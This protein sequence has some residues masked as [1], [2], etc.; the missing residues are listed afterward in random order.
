MKKSDITVILSIL[1]LIAVSFLIKSSMNKG[2]AAYVVINLAGEEYGRYDLHKDATIELDKNTVVIENNKVYMKDSDCPDHLCESQGPISKSGESIVC[3]PNKV[4]VLIEG[5][6]D[7]ISKTDFKLGTIVSVKI[8]DSSDEKIL[9]GCME[10]CDKYEAVCSRTSQS[11]ELYK[12]N[13][14]LI[15]VNSDGSY[16]VSDELY[17]MIEEGLSYSEMS[18]G[19]FD[20]SIGSLTTL[21]NFT[22]SCDNTV[23]SSADIDKALAS[24]SY[25][26]IRLD[27]DNRVFIDNPDTM[28]DMGGF[29]KGYIG[30]RICDYLKEQGINRAIVALG[31]DN[32]CLGADYTIG[33][34]KPFAPQGELADKV[35]VTD[36][37]I[38]TSGIYERYF[39][40]NGH[41]YHHILDPHT[42]YPYD[43]DL[44]SVSV[45]GKT[46]SESDFLATYLFS[47]GFEGAKE[48]AINNKLEVL[49][50]DASGDIFK[51]VQ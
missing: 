16:T 50:I 36:A 22:D 32:I 38:V 45:L 31:G 37:A 33:I 47:M 51:N 19:A 18:D 13:H 40:E 27:S 14:R 11:S 26:N 10:I 9:D 20:I 35:S 28:I 25:K 48:Y 4:S 12:L 17:E 44:V 3:L 46:G 42:G 1:I 5:E 23:P 29:A 2:E 7:P 43:N 15:S 41:L 39:E 21:W 30:D 8:Y 24:V 49:L 34:Q 6:S